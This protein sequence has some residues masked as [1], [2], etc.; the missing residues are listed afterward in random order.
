M[1]LDYC[2]T[3]QSRCVNYFKVLPSSRSHKVGRYDFQF[4]FLVS[5]PNPMYRVC[6][7]ERQA[8]QLLPC[9]SKTRRTLG[10]RCIFER[11]WQQ[12]FVVI[13]CVSKKKATRCLLITLENVDR[14]S[15]FFYHL[16]RK[17]ILDV[18]TTKIPPHMQYVAA[19][20]CESRKSKNVTDFD[21]ILS[22]M[23]T[24]SWGHFEGLT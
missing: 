19:L 14:F 9:V 1:Q 13:H 11:T 20:P 12:L 22:K 4:V 2:N 21:S 5:I 7:A 16:I 6:W 18:H 10:R 15:K 17:N 8:S 3:Y 24:C 23:F